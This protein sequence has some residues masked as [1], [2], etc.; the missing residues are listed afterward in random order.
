MNQWG[1]YALVALALFAAG[2]LTGWHERVLREP[3]MLE[4]QK[5][6]DNK[7][8]NIDKQKTKEINDEI[9]K[10]RDAIAARLSALKLQHPMR[11]VPVTGKTKL[12]AGG[13]EHA[14]QNGGSVSSDELRDYAA[15]CEGYRTEVIACTLFLDI[16]RQ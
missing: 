15:E 11:C 13:R 3:A 6:A 2:S 4:A 5:T 12:P 14:G 1:I 16:E 9:V 10:D 7:Q 8:C